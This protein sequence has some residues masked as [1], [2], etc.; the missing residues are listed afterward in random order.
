LDGDPPVYLVAPGNRYDVYGRSG[1]SVGD[2]DQAI[3]VAKRV[4]NAVGLATVLA[5]PTPAQIEAACTILAINQ[6]NGL[7]AGAGDSATA[8]LANGVVFRQYTQYSMPETMNPSAANVVVLGPLAAP[9][10][11][12]QASYQNCL[13]HF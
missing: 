6:N 11:Y 8:S 2:F 13:S 5:S 10:I 9:E 1:T 12:L 4:R 7:G 3:K